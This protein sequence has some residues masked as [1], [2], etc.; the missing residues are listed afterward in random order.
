MK[1]G[2]MLRHLGQPG[3]IGIYT[4]NI[5]K[6]LLTVDTHNQY[7]LLYRDP[8]HMG[9]YAHYP[10]A[11]ETVIDAPGKFWWDQVAVPRYIR[12]MKIDVVFNPK[13]SIPLNAG[14]KTVL[15]SHGGAFFVVPQ[16]Y[17][18]YN[19]AYFTLTNQFYFRRASAIISVTEL[20]GQEIVKYMHVASRKVHPIHESYNERCRVLPKENLA[21]VKEKYHL[22]DH[23]LLWV[24]GI[25]P[26]KNIGNLLR[27]YAQVAGQIPHQLVMAGFLRWK[28]S[29]DLQL[30]DELGLK[31]RIVFTNYVPP[32]DIPALYNLA[33]LFVFPSIY[34]GFGLPILEAMAC[35]CP[36]IT[37]TTGYAPE[38]A[39]GAG[40]LVNPYRPEEIAE[41]IRKVLGD[42]LQRQ[43]MIQD[44]LQWVKHF[45]WE[46]TARETLALFESLVDAT[47]A[48]A[49]PAIQHQSAISPG[50]N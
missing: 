24:G 11:I 6:A 47:Q 19:R 32:E 18:W 12:Q 13:L 31:D 40:L 37:S 41:A 29:D 23:F 38:V 3:G 21:E 2:L 10:N 15:I 33:D 34:E 42:D 49:P 7:H 27:A 16:A 50:G 36:V 20:G 9:S 30:I 25:S 39:G 48:P 5:V 17:P 44:G 22:P 1:I 14:C 45:S 8:A 28:F 26:L 43:K 46:K 35:G 4:A